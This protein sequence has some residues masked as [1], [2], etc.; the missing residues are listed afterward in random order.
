MAGISLTIYLIG[1]CSSFSCSPRLA[2]ALFS[3]LVLDTLAQIATDA[4][5][6]HVLKSVR[7]LRTLSIVYRPNTFSVVL[8]CI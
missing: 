6:V 4:Y 7:I 3:L 1:F 8:H 5:I 2:M